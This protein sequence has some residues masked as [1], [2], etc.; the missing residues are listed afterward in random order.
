M[1]IAYG[2]AEEQWIP[3]GIIEWNNHNSTL[4]GLSIDYPSTWNIQEK[5]NRFEEGIVYL[6][7]DSFVNVSGRINLVDPDFMRFSIL[8]IP[9]HEVMDTTKI[10]TLTT[11]MMD[12]HIEYAN[13]IEDDFE[14]RLIEGISTSR[15]KIGGENAG[16]YITVFEEKDSDYK[17]AYE[18]V[19]TVHNNRIYQFSFMSHAG[20]F[21]TQRVTEIRE[22]MFDSIKWFN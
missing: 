18:F 5:Q 21:D 11:T 20:V 2:Q 10:T 6:E 14:I 17:D 8:T 1:N 19:I 12:D 7:I 13:S 3:P 22:H 15:Y 4:L 9:L 16:S